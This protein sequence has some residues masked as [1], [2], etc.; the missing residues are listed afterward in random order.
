MV[1]YSQVRGKLEVVRECADHG[2]ELV[3]NWALQGL[4]DHDVT[5]VSLVGESSGR[6]AG[7]FSN[8]GDLL[9]AETEGKEQLRGTGLEHLRAD[10]DMAFCPAEVE[11]SRVSSIHRVLGTNAHRD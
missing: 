4:Y 8:H 6:E 3:L 1:L 10:T 11:G 5:P 7:H 9:V 2:A